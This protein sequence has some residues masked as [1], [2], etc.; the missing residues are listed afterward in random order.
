[1]LF[2]E[3][4]RKK[5]AVLCIKRFFLEFL[6]G[7]LYEAR[8]EQSTTKNVCVPDTLGEELVQSEV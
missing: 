4:N 5:I 6:E 3:Q 2:F 1:M 7:T 8:H